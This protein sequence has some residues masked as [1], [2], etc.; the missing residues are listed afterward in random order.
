MNKR[1][2]LENTLRGEPTDRVPV[3]AWRHWP[4]DDQRAAD[5]AEATIHFQKTYDWDIVKVTPA[6]TYC[7][8][9]YGVQSER[10]IDTS[11][12][13]APAKGLIKR[14]L[15]WTELR[16]LDP[17][18]GTL[19]KYIA[20]INL[21]DS[22]LRS[23]VTRE[24]VPIIA[25]IYSPL[26]QAAMIGEGN[27]MLRSMRTQPERLHTGLNVITDSV[28]N[29]IL[30]LRRTNIDGIFYVMAH[31][32]FVLMSDWEY[33]QFGLPYDR[34]VLDSLPAKWWLNILQLRNRAPM[35]PLAG[36]YP[37]P[38]INWDVQNTNPGLD[39][40][41]TLTRAVLC[42]GI[43][44]QEHMH[45]GTPTIVRDAAR[46][47]INHM[48]GR[49]LILAPEDNVPVTTPLSNLRAMREIVEGVGII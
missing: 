36:T 34:K 10:L 9:D 22:G 44:S 8:A 48:H 2:R 7:V 26:T 37:L 43:S 13:C 41:M 31:A 33:Q 6:S 12:D 39:E 19:A 47:V 3:A 30:A 4:G 35:F 14:S 21:V 24:Y 40:A 1:E 42:T 15:Q 32:D 45:L 29:F 28:L 11:G 38:I 23:G 16:S 20:A 25:V 27:T 18:R 49:R 46:A 17:A 5:L